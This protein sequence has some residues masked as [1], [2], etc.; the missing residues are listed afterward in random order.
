MLGTG[1]GNAQL[2]LHLDK[3][4]HHVDSLISEG[5]RRGAH[6]ALVSVGSHYCGVDFKII[7]R[8]HAPGRSEGDILAIESAATPGVEAFASRVSAT[9]VHC[10]LQSS[11]V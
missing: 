8:G 4:R 1:S 5:A 2:S 10:Q 3:A 11:G 9:G 7:G 6:A